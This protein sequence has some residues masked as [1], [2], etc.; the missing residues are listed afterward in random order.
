MKTETKTEIKKNIKTTKYAYVNEKRQHNW[1]ENSLAGSDEDIASKFDWRL[2][3]NFGPY[4]ARYK[5]PTTISVVL[6][7]LYTAFNLA[8]PYLIGVAIDRYI[9]GGDLGGLALIGVI[10]P[11]MAVIAFIW[12]KYATRSFRVTRSSISLVNATLQENISGM[13]V[14]QSLVREDRNHAEFD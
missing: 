6:M 9:S 12:Q 7:L 14:I 13:K 1:K 5:V 3:G 11:L 10:L 2:I 4:I 8:N